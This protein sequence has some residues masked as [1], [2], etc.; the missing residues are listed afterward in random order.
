MIKKVALYEPTFLYEKS[1]IPSPR[2]NSLFNNPLGNSNINIPDMR[3]Q[4]AQPYK[5]GNKSGR[6]QSN[7][8]Q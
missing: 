5:V 3:D 8:T 4:H 6:K 1:N 7:T 2:L